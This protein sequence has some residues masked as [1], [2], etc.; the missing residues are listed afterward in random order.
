MK[1]AITS[2]IVASAVVM[3]AGVQSAR[4]DII[5]YAKDPGALQPAENL[6]F[7]DPSLALTG[8]TVQGITNTTASVFDMTGLES[9][10]GSGGQANVT[11]QDGTFTYLLFEAHDPTTLFT[12]FE[13]N[14]TVFKASGPTPTGTVTVRATDS[15]GNVTTNA[16]NVGAGQNF[17]SLLATDP[18]LLRS[19]EVTSSV[20]LADMEQIRVGGLSTPGT[21]QV[22]EPASMLLFGSGLFALARRLRRR[23]EQ[24]QRREKSE[25]V[26]TSH[27]QNGGDDSVTVCS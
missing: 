26:A 20:D 11:G 6:L 4:A 16:Y 10:V 15:L 23:A 3:C 9:L 12:E 1:R 22:P 14:L 2:S 13:A 8:L 24:Q 21:N 17:F 7:N 19:I 27:R 18:D 25:P 5:F